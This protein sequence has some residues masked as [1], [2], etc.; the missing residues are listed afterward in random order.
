MRTLCSAGAMRSSTPLFFLASPSFQDRK[1]PLAYVSTSL[2]CRDFTVAITSWMLDLSSS[3]LSFASR[4]VR[5]CAVM[6]LAWSTR[7]PVSGGKSSASAKEARQ[8]AS[9]ARKQAFS[10][11]VPPL[12]LHLRRRFRTRSCSEFRHWFFAGECRLCPDDCRERPQR[13]VKSTH[14]VDV[15]ASSHGNA[16]LGAFE[17]RLQSQEI[18]IGFELGIVLRHCQ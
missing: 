2:P 16:V 5:L 17:L 7:R 8:N 3:S 18:G 12:E 13:R 10:F 6:I 14:R 11:T 4:S 1:R 9:P 15:I